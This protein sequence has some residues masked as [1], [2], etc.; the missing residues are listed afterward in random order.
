MKTWTTKS[1][2]RVIRVLSHRSNVFLLA[3]G[4]R[5]LLIDTSTRGNW[6]RLD[7]RLKAL[8]IS[9]VD[10]LILTHS[11]YDHADNARRLKD[12][13]GASVVIHRAEARHLESGGMPVP[14]GT[15]FLA[16]FLVSTFGR[17][18]SLRNVEACPCDILVDLKHDLS[19]LGLN[20]Y[21]LPT[22]GH[23]P[24][25]MSVIVDDEIAIVGDA[26]FGVFGWSV[27]PPY[28]ADL[29]Q[30]IES[31]AR[32]LDTGCQFFLPSHGS[33]KTRDQLQEDYA[34]RRKR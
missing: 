22:P 30:T 18:F 6:G 11:H 17:F 24:G 9:R 7:A 27:L 31:W 32:L 33:A 1:G 14:G 4:G 8:K 3:G 16:R 25:S 21:I 5:S 26:M 15:N 23:S 12:R 34:K 29:D 2:Y 19:L 10:Y 28:V 20:A 13:Y